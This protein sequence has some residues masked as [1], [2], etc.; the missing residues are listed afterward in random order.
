MDKPN[1]ISASLEDY[2]EI[3]YILEKEN[4]S[5]RAKDIAER[6]CV[7]KASVTGALRNLSAKGL[8]NYEP[9]SQITLTNEG[10]EIAREVIRR[11]GILKEFF[12][13]VLKLSPEEAEENACKIEHVIHIGAMKRLTKFLEFLKICPRAGSDWFEAFENYCNDGLNKEGCVTCIKKCLEKT[14]HIK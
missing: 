9:Y 8:I 6:M 13:F 12:E 4:N 5:A 10:R 14:S 1:D 2:L 11:H 7:Q 3:I